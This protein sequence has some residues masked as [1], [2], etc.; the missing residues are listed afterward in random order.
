MVKGGPARDSRHARRLLYSIWKVVFCLWKL[1]ADA[2][3]LRGVF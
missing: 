1:E 3:L 2:T